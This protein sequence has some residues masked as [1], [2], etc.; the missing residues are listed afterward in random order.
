[1]KADGPTPVE[2]VTHADKRLNIPTADVKDFVSEFGTSSFASE[3]ALS[4]FR[5]E[6]KKTLGYALLYLSLL[7]AYILFCWATLWL[8][9]ILFGLRAKKRVR[10][11]FIRNYAECVY[12]RMRR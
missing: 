8:L 11:I 2:A 10:A 12:G 3:F 7:L 4:R 9:D 1:M 6:P 5:E